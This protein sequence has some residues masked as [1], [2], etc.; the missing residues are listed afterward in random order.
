LRRIADEYDA[1][2]PEKKQFHG[3]QWSVPDENAPLSAKSAGL[4]RKQIHA[5][6]AVRDAEKR[7]PG[8]VRGAYAYSISSASQSAFLSRFFSPGKNRACLSR[9]VA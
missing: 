1:V 5:A 6:R 8:V 2:Q 4:T 9:Y 3:N 7:D